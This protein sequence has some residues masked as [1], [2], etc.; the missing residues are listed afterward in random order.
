MA[1]KPKLT[2]LAAFEDNMADA[3]GLVLLAEAATNLRVRRMRRELRERVGEAIRAPK[4]RW[5]E[6]DCV[7]SEDLFIVVLP[8]SRLG[9]SA[10]QNQAPLLRQAIVAGC[11][12]TETYLADRVVD[13]CRHTVRN[14][15]LGRIARIPMSVGDWDSVEKYTYRRRGITECVIAPWVRERASTAPNVVGEMLALVGIDKPLRKLDAARKVPI[16][17]TETDLQ[18]ISERRNRIAHAGDR[19]GR[20]RAT[21]GIDEV[22]SH[23]DGLES[24]VDAIDKVLSG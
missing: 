9:R 8:D 7:E 1:G 22:R 10:L 20:G 21:I 14:G 12:A 3:R 15:E 5:D 2:P 23:L 19:Q 11:A 16:G 4:K 24:V 18:R 17:T 13:R 6:L